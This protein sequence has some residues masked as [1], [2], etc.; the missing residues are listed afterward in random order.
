LPVFFNSDIIKILLA[1]GV[2]ATCQ[3]SPST[4][5]GKRISRHNGG[6]VQIVN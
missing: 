6:R 4:K 3:S 5:T 1:F 2:R